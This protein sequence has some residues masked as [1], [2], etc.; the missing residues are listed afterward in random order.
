MR[1]Y[2]SINNMMAGFIAVL[3]GYTSSVV[4]IIEAAH[5]VGAN[6]A[7]IAS[8]LLALGIG[9]GITSIAFSLYYRMPILIAWS[10]P[11]AVLLITGLSGYT[12]N[13]TIGAF[14][15]S[16]ILIILTGIT[17]TF[18]KIIQRIPQEI[19]TAILAGILL[20]FGLNAFKSVA[21]SFELCFA[22]FFVYLLGRKLFPRY[23]MLLVLMTGLIIAFFQGSFVFNKIHWQLSTLQF[24]HP[25]FNLKAI[26]NISLPLFIITM[27]SQNIPGLAVLKK[28]D[29]QVNVSPIISWTGLVNLLL[30]PFG[31]FSLNLAAIT[32]AICMSETAD[33][34]PKKRYLAA[35]YAGFFYII[36]GCFGATIVALFAAAPI[37]LIQMLA[38]L[39]LLTTIAGSLSTCLIKDEFREAALVAFLITASGITLFNID[40]PLWGLIAGAL[41]L[42]VQNFSLKTFSSISSK[43]FS[44]I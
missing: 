31:A 33:P 19:A 23:A 30:A 41:T 26:L 43:M 14:I 29:Y 8:W 44:K 1:K 7:E 32:A 28:F 11:G 42:A 21:N 16:A 15:V 25:D 18:T 27:A 38:G 36:A 34:N 22:M 10:T 39:A 2:F 3:V 37:A 9:M 40:A 13:Q 5:S 12:L 17:G 6:S 24:I 4:F 35:V 20:Q